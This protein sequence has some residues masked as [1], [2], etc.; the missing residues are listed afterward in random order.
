[1]QHEKEGGCG[2][3]HYNYAKRRGNYGRDRKKRGDTLSPQSGFKGK[4]EL[5]LEMIEKEEGCHHQG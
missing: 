3:R 5:V 2:T 1:L 4:R